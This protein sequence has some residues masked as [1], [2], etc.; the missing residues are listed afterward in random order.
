MTGTLTMLLRGRWKVKTSR[1][2][3]GAPPGRCSNLGTTT[4]KSGEEQESEG[5]YCKTIWLK[6]SWSVPGRPNTVGCRVRD[7]VEER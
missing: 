4:W 6:S 1:N 3:S 7:T 5:F 2:L